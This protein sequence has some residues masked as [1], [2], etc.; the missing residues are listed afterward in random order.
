MRR[1]VISFLKPQFNVSV[2]TRLVAGRHNLSMIILF[3]ERGHTQRSC[4]PEPD[5]Q[6]G[7]PSFVQLLSLTS[8]AQGTQG[9]LRFRSH[10]LFTSL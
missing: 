3:K 6:L 2:F 1:H 10:F 7:R 5:I 8:D 9:W 4:I